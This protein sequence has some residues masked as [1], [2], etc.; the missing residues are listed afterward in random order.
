MTHG[1]QHK[2]DRGESNIEVIS[3]I[4]EVEMDVSNPYEFLIL[5][6]AFIINMSIINNPCF[7]LSMYYNESK[8]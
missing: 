7:R 1:Y 4:T 8:I 2:N 5:K 6:I 3:L